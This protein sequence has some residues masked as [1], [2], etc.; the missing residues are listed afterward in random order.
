MRV[1][2]LSGGGSHGAW[3]AGACQALCTRYQYDAIVGTSVG[4]VNALGLSTGG[5]AALGKLWLGLRSSR[6]VMGVNWDWP[7]KLDGF[8]NFN[9]LKEILKRELYNA[10]PKIPCFATALSL[11]TMQVQ[12]IALTGSVSEIID[13]VTGSCSLAGIHSPVNGFVDGG[14]RE[15]VAVNFALNELQASEVHVVLTGPVETE[16]TVYK[17][18]RFF[19]VI[20]VALRALSAMISE[21][22]EN[23]L[24]GVSERVR[25]FQPLYP[26]NVSTLKYSPDHIREM[27]NEGFTQTAWPVGG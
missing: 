27:I 16:P 9:P 24:R 25:V 1:L 2:V 7:W 6:D 20:G 3:Q 15:T 18:W 19:P 11:R 10:A 8:L 4:A 5:P 23:D 21:I 13:A 22:T 26:H 14:H 12:N 17:A